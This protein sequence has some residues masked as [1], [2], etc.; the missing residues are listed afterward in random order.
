MKTS[1]QDKR[2][3]R[4]REESEDET[5]MPPRKTSR[6]SRRKARAASAANRQSK[7][8]QRVLVDHT[9]IDHMDDVV[10]PEVAPIPIMQTGG[11]KTQRGPRGGVTVAFPERLHDMLSAVEKEGLTE[12]VS[13]QPH[14]RCFI[15][16]EKKEFIADVMPR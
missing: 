11:K 2:M 15:V 9:Y 13:W 5:Q 7:P 10:E 4:S 3:S 16:H 1:A 8:V 12:I 6:V 14:G